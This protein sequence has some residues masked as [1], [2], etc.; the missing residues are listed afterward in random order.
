MKRRQMKQVLVAGS[1][2]LLMSVS[3][4]AAQNDA[5]TVETDKVPQSKPLVTASPPSLQ[6]SA[7]VTTLQAETG[8][9]EVAESVKRLRA[10]ARD[11]I[12]EVTRQDMAV[13]A[14]PDVIGP[15]VLPAM[16]MP[17]GMIGIGPNL[18]P[19]RKFINVFV[20]QM[21]QF[22]NLA[23]ADL[24]TLLVPE[25]KELAITPL[26]NQASNILLDIS[27]HYIKLLSL[28]QADKL[29]GGELGREAL[30][31][32]DDTT[33][34]EKPWKEIYKIIKEKDKK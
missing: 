29:D 28:A 26:W 32:Y 10:S 4:A 23:S 2:V 17:G 18:P 16:P 25:D 6:G 19:R 9:H 11:I 12:I 7:T 21:A 1:S 14:E 20:A 5:V 30:A 33:A 13:V 15:V 22:Y 34:F 27:S 24:N 3:L 31:V 8:V